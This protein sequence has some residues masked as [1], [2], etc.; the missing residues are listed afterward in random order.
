MKV[1]YIAAAMVAIMMGASFTGCVS[2][3]KYSELQA[4][5]QQMSQD[6]TTIQDNYTK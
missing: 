3:K 1:T 4:L 2:K 5:H 6:Y